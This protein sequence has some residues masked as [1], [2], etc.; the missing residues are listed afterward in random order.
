MKQTEYMK[1]WS[2]AGWLTFIMTA[3]L[4]TIFLFI[5]ECS[6]QMMI[7]THFPESSA[8]TPAYQDDVLECTSAGTAYISS[9]ENDI[10]SK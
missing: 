4:F 3:V 6:A 9:T 8:G 10:V 1:G 7:S 2:H 5:G